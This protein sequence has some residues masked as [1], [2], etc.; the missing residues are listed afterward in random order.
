MGLIKEPKY[1]YRDV[2]IIPAKISYIEHREEC[3]P[4]YSNGMLP[5]FTAPMDTV[6]D[7]KNFTKFIENK[8]NGI[9]PRTIPLQTRTEYAING[10]W[11]AFSLKEFEKL[12]CDVNK[13]IATQNKMYALI[14]VANGHMNKILEL[15]SRA[16][17]I[18]GDNIVI[19]AG[20]IANPEAY[21]EYSKVGIDYVRCGI[22]SGFGCL[23]TS[24]TG[25]HWPMASLIDDVKKL[26]I[27]VQHWHDQSGN[28]YKSVPKIIADGGIRGYSDI[29][30]A[31]ALGA[32]YV[33]IGSVFAKMFESA[34]QKVYGAMFGIDINS[35][36]DLHYNGNHA[37]WEGTYKGEKYNI[38][39]VYATFYGMASREGQIAMNGA[40]TKTSEGVKKS[41]E[42]EYTMQGWTENFIDYLRS[43]MSYTNNKTLEQFIN[44]T[45][46]TVNSQNAVDV[47]NK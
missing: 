22:G 20:N 34:S 7:N 25:V 36:R 30:K 12:F 44:E 18:Y 26:K 35:F 11:S 32:D 5:L 33:M 6:V 17:E 43:A 42:V 41:L 40:K 15:S 47:V 23:S 45:N 27:S 21:L 3:N 31:L 16:K 29:I 39:P 37:G 4:F 13:E 10:I 8:I 46:L 28:I 2:T 38:G 24:N 1:T 9:M 19:M 14:D